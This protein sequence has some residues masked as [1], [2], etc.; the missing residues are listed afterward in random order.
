MKTGIITYN[1]RDRGRKHR[2]QDR[3][4]DAQALASIV[5]SGEVQERVKNRDLWGYVEHWPR[6]VFGLNP[7]MGGVIPSGPAAGKVARLEPAFVTTFIEAKPD[8]TIRHEAEFQDNANGRLAYRAHKNRRGGFSSVINCRDCAGVDVPIGFYGFD[9]VSEPNFTTNRGYVLD[10]VWDEDGGV[11][12]DGTDVSRTE[13]LLLDGLYTKLQ[14]DYEAMA[15]TVA[16]L[17]AENEE[18]IAMLAKR[19]GVDQTAASKAL[20]RLDSVFERQDAGMRVLARLD[21]ASLAK[22]ADRFR[23]ADLPGLES[24]ADDRATADLLSQVSDL[25]SRFIP[26][27]RR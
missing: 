11:V 24:S 26:G 15:K 27:L 1:V 6:K 25:A 5:N 18:L 10:G 14:G 2:G 22:E 13:F 16:R 17:H 8:G 4:F 9:Y 7:G 20:A 23:V 12:M 3:N 21:D 19:P